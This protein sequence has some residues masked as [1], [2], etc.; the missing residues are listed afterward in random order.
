[1]LVPAVS[2][3]CHAVVGTGGTLGKHP[4]VEEGDNHVYFGESGVD[5]G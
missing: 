1:M 5:V 2:S 3:V 4:C